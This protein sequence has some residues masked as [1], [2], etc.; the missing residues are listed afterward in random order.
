MNA[1]E[2][3]QKHRNSTANSKAATAAVINEHHDSRTRSSKIDML[4]SDYT[5]QNKNCCACT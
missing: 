1:W 2:K 4:I 5:T 3:K